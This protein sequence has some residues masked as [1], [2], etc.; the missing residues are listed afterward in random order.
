MERSLAKVKLHRQT[1][2]LDSTHNTEACLQLEENLFK[3]ITESGKKPIIVTGI[4]GNERAQDIMPLLSQNTEALYLVEPNQP[5]SCSAEALA[6]MI[7]KSQSVATIP[8]QL[9]NLFSK[10][11]L[12]YR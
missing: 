3:H 2:I 6:A 1:L 5:R 10:R 8:S 9:E 11:L 7:P 4:L 12:P